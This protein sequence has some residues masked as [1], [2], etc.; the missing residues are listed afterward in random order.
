MMAAEETRLLIAGEQVE[1]D[2]QKLE[3]EN[4]ATEE[5]IATVGAASEE[6]CSAAVAAALEAQRDWERT[7]AVE[8]GEMLHEVATSLRDRTEELAVAMTAEGGKP[9]I[10]NRDEVG[11]TAAAF[12]Y[13]AEIGR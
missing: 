5:I 10:E 1:G 12:D 2:G 3:V 4:P 13:Y 6:Q 7:P 8:R 11:W 9:L